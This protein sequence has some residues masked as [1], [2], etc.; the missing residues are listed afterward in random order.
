MLNYSVAELRN[1]YLLIL[2]ALR[3]GSAFV[4]KVLTLPENCIG[5][6]VFFKKNS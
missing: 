4:F 1:N 3:G 6:P 2:E 5:S